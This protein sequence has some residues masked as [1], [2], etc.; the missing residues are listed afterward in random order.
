MFHDI[1]RKNERYLYF[2]SRIARFW[3]LF[4]FLFVFIVVVFL[5]SGILWGV[6]PTKNF[7]KSFESKLPFSIFKIIFSALFL[8][9]IEQ[10]IKCLIEVDFKPKWILRNGHRLIYLYASLLFV[11]YVYFAVYTKNML[12]TFIQNIPYLT[13]AILMGI[14]KVMKILLWIAFGFSLKKILLIIQESKTL[15]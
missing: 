13:I 12:E 5:L 4:L 2:S 15:V 9:G 3:G 6:W 7:T 10:F 8:L 14:L 1:I 11:I